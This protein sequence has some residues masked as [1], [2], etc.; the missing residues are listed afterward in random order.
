MK[1]T[2]YQDHVSNCAPPFVGQNITKGSDSPI[3]IKITGG[4]CVNADSVRQAGLG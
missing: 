3:C 4:S 2:V 1:A